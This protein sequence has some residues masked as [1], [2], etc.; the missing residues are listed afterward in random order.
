[1]LQRVGEEGKLLQR[2][3]EPEV[4]AN[5]EKVLYF[6]ECGCVQSPVV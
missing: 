5:G 6:D 1:V 3:E 2:Y 4:E